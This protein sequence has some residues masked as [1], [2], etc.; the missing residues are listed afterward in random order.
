MGIRSRIQKAIAGTFK[1][2]DW[3]DQTDNEATL[4]E[5][6]KVLQPVQE[7]MPFQRRLRDAEFTPAPDVGERALVQGTVPIDEAWLIH[8]I[9]AEHN[10]TVTHTMRAHIQPI[11]NGTT[12]YVLFRG[13]ILTAQNSAIQGSSPYSADNSSFFS[14]RGGPLPLALPQDIVVIED[15]TGLITIGRVWNISIRYEIVPVPA[16]FQATQDNWAATV[17]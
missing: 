3:I 14:V 1:L 9:S 17:L 11:R 2:N 7:L 5:T 16:D 8:A 10:D 12:P 13:S 15:Q 6:S 4:Q